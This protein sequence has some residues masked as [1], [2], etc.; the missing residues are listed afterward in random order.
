MSFADP[1][2]LFLL[3]L[4]PLVLLAQRR[5]QR[6]TRRYAVR[7]TAVDTLRAAAVIPGRWRRLL[8]VV[9]LL[10]ALALVPVAL[11]RPRVT[12]RVPIRDASLMLVLDHSGSMAAA[13]VKPTRLAA[14]INAA[15]TFIDQVPS[16]IRVGAVTFSTDPDTEQRPEVDHDAARS[17]I[18]AQQADGGTDTG[19]ALQV[20]LDLLNAGH[21]NHAPA[22]IVLLSDGAANSGISPITVA[23]QAKQEHVPIY[24]VA[25]GTPGGAIFAPNGE[26]VPVP[27]DPQLM[28]TIAGASGGRSFD[29]QTA[30]DLSSIYTT[31]GQ[32]LSTVERKRDVTV[33]VLL[34]AGVLLLVAAVGSVRSVAVLP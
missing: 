9:A 14:A 30:D 4:V 32:K 7:F 26:L 1:V 23:Q 31:L 10:L 12:H 28:R 21:K 34:L 15:N 11:A 27:P 22:A 25:L 5:L 13:D 19:P 8:P 29:A 33:Y 3:V 2:W 20:A 16:N 24:T 6:R 17:V 18:N